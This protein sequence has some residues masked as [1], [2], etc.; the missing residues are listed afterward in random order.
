MLS[1]SDH[2]TSE[3]QPSDKPPY[4]ASPVDDKAVPG[5]NATGVGEAVPDEALQSQQAGVDLAKGGETLYAEQVDEAVPQSREAVEGK[6]GPPAREAAGPGKRTLFERLKRSPFFRTR[7]RT[8]ITAL[9]C[10]P[11]LLCAGYWLLGLVAFSDAA[12]LSE[13]KGLVH[14]R[15]ENAAQWQLAQVNQLVVR[16]DRVR[17]GENSGARLLF[18]DVSTVD[19]DEN[20]EV[21]VMEVASRRGGRA[22]DVAVKTW[23]GKTIVRAVRFVDPSSTFRVETPT[24][25]TVVRGARFTVDVAED[26]KTQIDLQEGVAEVKMKDQKEE[27][28]LKMGQRITL[29]PGG[30]YQMEKV[31][32]PDPQPMYD[33]ITA[34]WEESEDTL[35]LELTEG[36]VNQFL[37]AMEEETELFL[38]GTQVWFVDGEMRIATTVVKPTKV[39]LSVSLDAKVVDGKIEPRVKS[40]AAGMALPVPAPVLNMV[41]D[42][43]M[44]RL[45]GYLDQAYDYVSFSDLQIEDGVLIVVGRKQPDAPVMQ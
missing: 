11:L 6:E 12:R 25:S 14:T 43:V 15:K 37:A 16:S 35:H 34:A 22:V 19:L 26:G 9:V 8:I 2:Q 3:P 39:D 42:T 5:E 33:R 40:I 38:Q 30:T 4:E 20:T 17:T 23:V 13:L 27:I 18:F 24:A 21:A 1:Q 28:S 29:E 10:V 45:E 7:R 44:A 32:D 31:F 41:V 36:E